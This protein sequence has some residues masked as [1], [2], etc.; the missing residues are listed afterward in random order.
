MHIDIWWQMVYLL[1]YPD[2]ISVLNLHDGPKIQ[3]LDTLNFVFAQVELKQDILQPQIA[4]DCTNLG[5]NL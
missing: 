2:L 4:I 5:H 3:K 1:G